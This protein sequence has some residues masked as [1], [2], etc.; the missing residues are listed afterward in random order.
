MVTHLGGGFG[1]KC[2][3]HF[4]AH[5]AALARAARRPVRLVLNRRQGQST[6][7]GEGANSSGSCRGQRL[8]LR[9]VERLSGSL[10]LLQPGRLQGAQELLLHHLRA[11][12][13]RLLA[14]AALPFE[15]EM[16]ELGAAVD[17]GGLIGVAFDHHRL[18][19]LGGGDVDDVG[20]IKFA[21]GIIV[22]D[23]REPTE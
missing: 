16:G 13:Q 18:T 11:L 20:Q 4:E 21:R 8:V 14:P 12:V 5:V 9:R 10:D 2:D 15:L 6:R 17:P 1:G 22:A 19:P 3:F 7:R 23:A